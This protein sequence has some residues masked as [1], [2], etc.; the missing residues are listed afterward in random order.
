MTKLSL[1]E[2]KRFLGS[3][4]EGAMGNILA[5]D[6]WAPFYPDRDITCNWLQSYVETRSFGSWGRVMKRNADLGPPSTSQS[7]ALP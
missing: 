1:R 4:Q 2:R 5:D 3:S 6:G 7:R